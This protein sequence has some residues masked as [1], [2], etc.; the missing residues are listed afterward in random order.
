M[1]SPTSL[2]DLIAG[3]TPILDAVEALAAQPDA[4]NMLARLAGIA[5]VDLAGAHKYSV[6]NRQ[7]EKPT[8]ERHAL[9]IR[10]GGIQRV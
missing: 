2:A 3:I 6:H 1:T 9:R 7:P 4:V 10:H 5:D 8:R